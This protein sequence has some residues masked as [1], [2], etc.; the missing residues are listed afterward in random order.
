MI[1]LDNNGNFVVNTAGRLTTTGT[2]GVQCAKGETR[3]IQ[4]SWEADPY[5]GRNELVWTISQSVQD[6]SADLNR[7]ASKYI[8]VVFVT[9]N[10]EFERYE[11]QGGGGSA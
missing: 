7:I 9:Y 6:R 4:G 2:P 11:I 10:P 3:C 8:N 5:F 1:A